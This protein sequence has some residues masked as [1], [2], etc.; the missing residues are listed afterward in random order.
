MTDQVINGIPVD[1]TR[2][3]E[4]VY[5]WNVLAQQGCVGQPGMHFNADRVGFN[6]G[7]QLEEMAE[8]IQG[9]IA[10]C[11]DIGSRNSLQS[12]HATLKSYASSFKGGGF[13]GAV[14]RGDREEL[15]DGA[16]D[17]AFVSINALLYQTP[18][19]LGALTAVLTANA[20]KFPE[21]CVLRDGNGKILK[22][23]GWTKPDLTPFID[24]P[25]D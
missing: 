19:W 14:L 20:K 11:V 7:M 5:E 2:L 12:L 6:I 1:G 23:A 25:I 4:S 16:I 13:H 8:T 9:V 3:V 10:G 18:H 15:L 17:V 24:Q 21:G 22:P